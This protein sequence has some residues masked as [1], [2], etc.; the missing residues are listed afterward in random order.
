MN[1]NQINNSEMLTLLMD[2]ELESSQEPAIFSELAKNEE[3][4]AEFHDHLRFKEAASRD[5][6]AFAL[7]IG[8]TAGV[9]SR[10]GFES[11]LKGTAAVGMG[12]V[13]K[14]IWI[15]LTTAITS[16]VITFFAIGGL[17]TDSS[18]DTNPSGAPHSVQ[19]EEVQVQTNNSGL[20]GAPAPM[21]V[22]RD[23]P[24]RIIYRNVVPE[25]YVPAQSA[26][27][28]TERTLG[29]EL[30][31]TAM[32]NRPNYVISPSGSAMFSQAQLSSRARKEYP[33]V[34]MEAQFAPHLDYDNYESSFFFTLRGMNSKSYPSADESL[35][36]SQGFSNIAI[37]LYYEF[38]DNHSF[39][40]EIGQEPFTQLANSTEAGMLQNEQNPILFWV[41]LS[42][43]GTLHK[44]SFLGDLQPYGQITLGSTQVGPMGKAIVGLQY[45]TTSGFGINLGLEGSLLYYQNNQTK[46]NTRKLGLTYGLQYKF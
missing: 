39:G 34:D 19:S 35:Q 37:G 31:T 18:S 24:P 30:A 9:F 2:G 40:M 5:T 45:N 17:S 23:A 27:N 4:R 16:A 8:A 33:E 21:I 44:M 11:A 14:K 32:N 46:S 42:Y 6:D 13:L 26:A 7:P 41:G 36:S 10:L 29:T 12:V 22:Y 3:L 1:E 38:T 20:P 25:G 15:P 43:R 28:S